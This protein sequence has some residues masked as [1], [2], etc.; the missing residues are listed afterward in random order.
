MPGV[1]LVRILLILAVPA[2]AVFGL[3]SLMGTFDGPVDRAG[4]AQ[5]MVWADRVFTTKPQL[6]NWLEAR[7]IAYEVWVDRHPGVAPWEPKPKPKPAAPEKVASAPAAP[8]S[9]SGSD[10]RFSV[11]LPIST[12]TLFVALLTGLGALLLATSALPPVVLL[13]TGHARVGVLVV[14]RR[15]EIAAA[16]LSLLVGVGLPIWLA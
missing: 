3:G 7:G 2:V 1:S 13:S 16:G 10:G 15:A 9:P 14:D 11:S 12:T 5:A 4:E 6:S 8:K